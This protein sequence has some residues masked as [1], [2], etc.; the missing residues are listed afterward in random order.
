[1]SRK[2]NDEDV[3]FL[4]VLCDVYD[5]LWKLDT[6]DIEQVTMLIATQFNLNESPT[7]S[8]QT[9]SFDEK[10]PETW[11]RQV[12]ESFV[13]VVVGRIRIS[14]PWHNLDPSFINVK[15]EPG[16]AFGTGDHPTTKLCLAWLQRTVK[17]NMKVLDFGT[18]SGVLAI[19]AVLFSEGVQAVGVDID[20]NAVD[21]AKSNAERNQLRDKI[22]FCENHDEPQGMKYDVIIANILAEPLKCLAPKLVQ[23]METGASIGLSGVLC[24][25]AV[26]VMES[27][28]REGVFLQQAEVD[29]NWA[30]LI[31]RR[32]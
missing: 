18:G 30:L 10:D 5:Y 32:P 21:T 3:W 26:D 19:A 8:L 4:D 20:L 1:M 23:S 28:Q 11:V 31:G 25:Q 27:Y 17:H 7:F 15:L 2:P 6:C 14:F 24:H 29:N 12:Q 22:L 13:P 9:D 16:C